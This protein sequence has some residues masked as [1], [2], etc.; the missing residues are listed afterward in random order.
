[1]RILALMWIITGLVFAQGN[2]RER[3]RSGNINDRP[4]V[5]S[6]LAL[7]FWRSGRF[8]LD[9]TLSIRDAGYED[10]ITF[11]AEEP[12]EDEHATAQIRLTALAR[13]SSRFFFKSDGSYQYDWFNQHSE[14][15]GHRGD[16]N[17]GFYGLFKRGYIRFEAGYDRK[18]R[19][20]SSEINERPLQTSRNGGVLFQHLI[21]V[22]NLVEVEATH[23]ELE[24]QKGTL[25]QLLDQKDDGIRTLWVLRNFK[26]LWPFL[27][28][29]HHDVDFTSD[30]APRQAETS[31]GALGFRN[32]F[33][34][35]THFNF[36]AG[37]I[38]LSYILAEDEVTDNSLSLE[39]YLSHKVTRRVSLE[40]GYVRQP[41]YSVSNLG[42]YISSRILAGTNIQMNRN[43][44]WT[45]DAYFGTN[46]Y[47]EKFEVDPNLVRT[48]DYF[49]SRMTVEW[50]NA[51]A[52]RAVIAFEINQRDSPIPELEADQFRVGFE[53]TY[54]P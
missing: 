30:E 31:Q 12:L 44:R 43:W 11:Q 39:G 45:L 41:V 29:S 19:N 5:D 40:T 21:G 6:E 7:S 35:R 10:N 52:L 26:N 49:S 25:S 33:S 9:P 13:F 50:N 22:N 37:V 34:E 17:L 42:H 14:F 32:D 2:D 23:W 8:G 47:D 46:R 51:K 53:L 4:D 18:L 3:F 1:M 24:F 36:K 48:D 15:G 38:R 27:E 54:R 16:L 28:L 20:P